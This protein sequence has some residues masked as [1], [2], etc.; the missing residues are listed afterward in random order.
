MKNIEKEKKPIFSL[1]KYFV[2]EEKNVFFWKLATINFLK[3]MKMSDFVAFCFDLKKKNDPEKKFG[4]SFDAE[5]CVLSIPAVF[6]AIPALLAEL[7]SINVSLYKSNHFWDDLKA[8]TEM[9]LKTRT[10][11]LRT[12]SCCSEKP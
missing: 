5:N 1:K 7:S 9:E 3:K 12:E 11:S 6:M 8:D 10:C 4:H 2:R